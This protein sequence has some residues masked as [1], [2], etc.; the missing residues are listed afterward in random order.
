MTTPT[1]LQKLL[2]KAWL[3]LCN[4]GSKPGQSYLTENIKDPLTF[5]NVP[6]DPT[7]S[8]A[9]GYDLGESIPDFLNEITIGYYSIGDAFGFVTSAS[10]TGLSGLPLPL[11]DPQ[12]PDLKGLTFVPNTGSPTSITANLTL[13]SFT[14]SGDWTLQ[15]LEGSVNT[16]GTGGCAA[17]PAFQ[18][19][20][21]E[22]SESNLNFLRQVRSDLLN[23]GGKMGAWYVTQYNTYQKEMIAILQSSDWAAAVQAYNG[24]QVWGAILGAIQGGSGNTVTLSSDVLSNALA[25]IGSAQQISDSTDFQ[26]TISTILGYLSDYQ[27]PSGAS[28]SYSQILTIVAGETPPEAASDDAVSKKIN[29]KPKKIAPMTPSMPG[30]VSSLPAT[31]TQSWNGTFTATVPGASVKVTIDL[32]FPD[33]NSAPTVTATAF[34]L[35]IPSYTL[36]YSG[37]N[38]AS[39]F[40]VFL[41]K[42]F[43]PSATSGIATQITTVVNDTTPATPPAVSLN[44]QI[45]NKITTQLNSQ[46]ASLWPPSKD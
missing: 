20:A 42:T 11:V 2:I 28:Y 18:S 34:T 39:N 43:D 3:E 36:T 21:V 46:I 15:Q 30:A 9:V 23:K 22:P 44:Q 29:V 45:L 5:K 35:T 27:D 8:D 26:N 7:A 33:D 12:N 13:P 24:N 17:Q 10:V 38:F 4:N 1:Y 16:T 40:I 19:F 32:T 6:A 25:L 31:L 14:A 41:Q 37:S